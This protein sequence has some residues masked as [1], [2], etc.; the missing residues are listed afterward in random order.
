MKISNRNVPGSRALRALEATV[1]LG[2]ATLAAEELNITQAAVSHRIR[3]LEEELGQPLFRRAGRKL[4]PTSAALL[5]ADA[6]R[7]SFAPLEAA[8]EAIGRHPAS[9]SLTVSM[10]PALASKW[11]APRLAEML[12]ELRPVDLRVTA[13]REF[14]DF[15]RDRVDAA[16]RYGRGDWQ[17]VC[18]RHLC[19]EIIAPVIA[20]G[21]L[22]QIDL[23]RSDAFNAIPLLN[24]DNPDTWE[25]WFEKSSFV[26]PQR[27]SSLFFDDD[28][29]MIEAAIAGTGVALGRAALVAHDLRTGR[30]VAPFGHT[31]IS[32]FSYWFVQD[33]A[34]TEIAA[35]REFLRWTKATLGHDSHALG[36][37]K[38][39][40][41]QPI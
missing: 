5:L 24:C 35:H 8:L 26:V 12:R 20:P 17:N 13:S 40:A 23:S 10:L 33:P 36:L 16:I 38:S 25:N 2:K 3:E 27:S 18:S 30:L 21:L 22:S 28:A 34:T 14:V 7:T 9:G 31:I 4:E 1:R 32:R 37:A 41:A 11:L 6:I 15:R 39:G 19:D 29:A